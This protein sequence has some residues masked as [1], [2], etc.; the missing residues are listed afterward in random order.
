MNVAA[1]VGLAVGDQHLAYWKKQ[2][3][4]APSA[5]ELPTDRSRSPVHTFASAR[6]TIVLPPALSA[7]LQQL[8]RQEG[9]SLFTQI[10]GP[11]CQTLC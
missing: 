5:L 1:I 3:E 4:G 2:L 6:Q 8:S 9:A 7:A 11:G 10:L